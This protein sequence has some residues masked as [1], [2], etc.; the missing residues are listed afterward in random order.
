MT[1]NRA[2][3]EAKLQMVVE[4]YLSNVEEANRNGRL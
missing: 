2:D 1:D 3:Y 4:D